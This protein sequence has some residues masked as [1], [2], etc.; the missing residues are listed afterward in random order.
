[1][2]KTI[3]SNHNIDSVYA[4]DGNLSFYPRNWYLIGHNY[5]K[6]GPRLSFHQ[7]GFKKYASTV[8][9]FAGPNVGNIS[10]KRK[11]TGF[12]LVE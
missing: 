12:Y 2:A 11:P 6:Y 8:R 10:E 5:S 1:M 9:K 7:G 3:K 4:M